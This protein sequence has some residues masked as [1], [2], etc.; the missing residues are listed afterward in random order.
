[1]KRAARKSGQAKCLSHQLLQGGTGGSACLA[2]SSTI[3]RR[4]ARWLVVPLAFASLAFAEESASGEKDLTGWKWANFAILA[5]GIGYLLVKQAG[6]YFAARSVEIQKGI[7]DAQKLRAEAE[8]RAAA[9]DARLAIL[10]VEV[11]AMRKA[12]L[13]EASQEAHR[14]R[15]ETAHEMAKI[16]ANAE[17][18]ISSA[19]KAAQIELKRY[20][21]QLAIDLAREKVRERMTPAD[22][23]TLVRN[24]VT[25]LSRQGTTS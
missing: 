2:L 22:Q 20:S 11:E 25:D 6:P 13:E 24:F 14:F 3:F 16:Q 8:E 9:M 12:S 18:E 10:G 1:V 17:R 19:L 7:E 5:A 23:E 4:A 21:A 15:Q